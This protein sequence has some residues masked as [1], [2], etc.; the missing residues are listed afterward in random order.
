MAFDLVLGGGH[1]IGE[2]RFVDSTRSTIPGRGTACRCGAR[3]G[4]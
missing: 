1:V 2:F 3:T 4:P